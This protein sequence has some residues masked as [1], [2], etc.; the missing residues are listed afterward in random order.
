MADRHADLSPFGRGAVGSPQLFAEQARGTGDILR[1][2]GE[3]RT[4]PRVYQE[5]AENT[6]RRFKAGQEPQ[7]GD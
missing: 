3:N 2:E 6:G 5:I 7:E 1:G 4:A